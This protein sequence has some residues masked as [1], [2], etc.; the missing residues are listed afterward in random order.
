VTIF[1]I[2]ANLSVIQS[3][4]AYDAISADMGIFP[5][6]TDIRIKRVHNSMEQSPSSEANSRSSSQGIPHFL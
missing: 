6:Q 5:F 1:R 4:S 3:V 2:V